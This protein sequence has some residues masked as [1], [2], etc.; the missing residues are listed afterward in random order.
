MHTDPTG[1]HAECRWLQVGE[2]SAAI[3]NARRWSVS[4]HAEP[5]GVIQ[6][7]C[8]GELI[9]YVVW[10]WW[11]WL[12]SCHNNVFLSKGSNTAPTPT[13]NTTTLC[14]THMTLTRY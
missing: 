13:P 12:L 8:V 1:E 5:G 7:V 14:Q 9:P 4:S 2:E 10:L 11:G 3:M 6:K